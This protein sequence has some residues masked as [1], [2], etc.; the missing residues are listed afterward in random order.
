MISEAAGP[1]SE[2]RTRLT[3]W[4]TLNLNPSTPVR[5]RG[6]TTGTGEFLAY[7]LEA[8]T[9]PGKWET[10]VLPPGHEIEYRIR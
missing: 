2:T 4:E 9:D 3:F 8:E 1:G 7:A 6:L 5:V 10:R